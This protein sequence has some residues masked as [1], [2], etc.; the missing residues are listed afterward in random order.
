[1]AR[2]EIAADGSAPADGQTV[3][4]DVTD[5]TDRWRYRCPNGHRGKAWEP[6]NNHLYCRGCK[7]Q[8]DA[9]EDVEC[10]HYELVDLKTNERIPYAAIVFENARV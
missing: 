6:T 1:M 2:A 7:R 5:E 10:E 9:G 4:I 3:R 8:L